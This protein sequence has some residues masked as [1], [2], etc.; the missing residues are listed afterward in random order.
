MINNHSIA[1]MAT[2]N[3]DEYILMKGWNYPAP[4]GNGYITLIKSSYNI[5]QILIE[6]NIFIIF[7]ITKKSEINA[8]EMYNKWGGKIFLTF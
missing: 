1:Y 8:A 4:P 6:S 5:F 2:V 3:H 7:I